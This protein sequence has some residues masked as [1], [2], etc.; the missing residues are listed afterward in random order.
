MVL[1]LKNE[2][3]SKDLSLT[4][5]KVISGYTFSFY[6]SKKDP[7]SPV[8]WMELYKDFLPGENERFNR[9]YFA[10]LIIESKRTSSYVASLGT[11]HFYVSKYADSD[12]GLDLAER[13]AT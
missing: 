12:F 8:K 13:I 1:P 10:V 2:L 11:A 7:E 6:F 5:S 3:L 9:V 4:N